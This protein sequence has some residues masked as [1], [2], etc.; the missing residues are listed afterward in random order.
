MFFS[1]TNH[2]Y[3]KDGK[4]YTPVSE[5]L[6]KFKPPFPKGLMAE[7]CAPKLGLTPEEVIEMW[8]L[9]GDISR[10]YGTTIHKAIE[11]WI[12]YGHFSKVAD[13]ERMGQ[14]FAEK[15]NRAK[16]KTEVIVHDEELG[17]AGTLDQLHVVGKK[18]VFLTDVKT[19]GDLD[20]KPNGKFLGPLKDLPFSKINEYRLQLST[21]GYLLERKGFKVESLALEHW[22]GTDFT[23]IALERIDISPLIATIK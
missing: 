9:N 16:I 11:Y 4:R 14:K 21:Y 19:N 6:A 23:T 3:T 10:T 8:D 20:K 2:E 17:I 22:N 1:E 7:K 18:R 12:R 15:Y 5:F 13:L